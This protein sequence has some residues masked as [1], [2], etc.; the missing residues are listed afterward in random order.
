MTTLEDYIQKLKEILNEHGN[1]PLYASD[2]AE[3][4]SYTAVE[5]GPGVFYA[6]ELKYRLD[7]VYCEDDVET[8]AETQKI[9]I[10]VLN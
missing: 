10:L 2:D 9:P 1:L 3:G 6:D 4:N 5:Y 7:Y 8:D